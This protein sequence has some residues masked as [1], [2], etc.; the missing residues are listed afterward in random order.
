MAKT[1]L[2][3]KEI[4]VFLAG[5]AIGVAGGYIANIAVTSIYRLIDKD[6]SIAN[7]FTLTLSNIFL[8]GLCIWILRKMKI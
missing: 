6:Y 4:K 8:F 7:L 1:K 2:S 5:V 3:K